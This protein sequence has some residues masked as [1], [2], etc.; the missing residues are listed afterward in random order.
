MR[1]LSSAILLLACLVL[2]GCA[3]APSGA[4][5]LNDPYEST[6]RAIFDFNQK[7]DRNFMLP[8]AEFY[9]AAVPEPARDGV[10]NFLSNLNLPVVF[11]ND[12]LQ[13]E[14]TRAAQDMGRF[15][16]N[17]TIGVGGLFDPATKMGVPENNEDFGQTLGVWGVGEGPYLVLPLLGPDP[18]R[19][20]FGQVADVFLDP[21]T[22]VSI[23]EH[24]Y[25]SAA[26]EYAEI[27]DL[28]S[29]N[30]DTLNDIERTSVD[31]YATM[32]SLYRQMRQNEINNGK[33]ETE[34]LPNF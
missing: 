14:A 4:N 33:T 15:G 7:L 20:A 28:R 25:W 17:T 8:T 24:F 18:P 21:W 23:R 9:V 3:S 27:V 29:R 13:G 30:I 32:R 19:D 6:N 2:G 12:V 16:L 34:N 31:Y 26:R 11:I 5:D 22:Y 1:G 10:H